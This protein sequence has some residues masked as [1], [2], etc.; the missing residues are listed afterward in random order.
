MLVLVLVSLFVSLSI[1]CKK[2]DKFFLI[3]CTVEQK[4]PWK[5]IRNFPSNYGFRL[6]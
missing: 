4:V 1:I 3:Y 6:A 5:D 2:K